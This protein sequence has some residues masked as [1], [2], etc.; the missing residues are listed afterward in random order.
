WN[1]LTPE[2][3]AGDALRFGTNSS[4]LT[5]AQLQRIHFINPGGFSPGDYA[6]IIYVDGTVYPAGPASAD[7]TND[8]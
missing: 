5:P 6:A 2:R 4:G 1:S 7:F 8:W 3:Y